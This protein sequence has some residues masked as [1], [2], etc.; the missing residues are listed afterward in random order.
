MTEVVNPVQGCL[1]K[2][3]AT[4]PACPDAAVEYSLRVGEQKVPLNA[5]IADIA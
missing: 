3:A 2:M 1:S 5:R 4:L